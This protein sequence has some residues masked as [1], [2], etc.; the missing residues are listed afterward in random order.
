[1]FTKTVC[2]VVFIII[3]SISSEQYQLPN[4]SVITI[5]KIVLCH[6]P[7]TYQGQ[8]QYKILF[9]AQRTTILKITKPNEQKSPHKH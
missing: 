7:L 2:V 6:F 4:Q 9:K 8:P 3:F 5:K 1:M